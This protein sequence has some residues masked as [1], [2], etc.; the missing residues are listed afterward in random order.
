LQAQNLEEIDVTRDGKPLNVDL[1]Q[2]A[3]EGYSAVV[4]D[5]CD[6][7]G[8]R[9]QTMTPGIL[10]F[11]GPGTLAGRVR[12]ARSVAVSEVPGIHYAAEIAFLDSLG[13]GD[14]VLATAGD[15]PA[16][17]WGELFSAAA[18]ARGCRGAVI[19]G[20]VRDVLR[21]RALGFSV[22][23]RGARP[24]DSLGR[25][26]LVDTEGPLEVAGVKVSNGDIVVADA[27][28][29]VVVPF[30]AAE[31]VLP[32]ALDKAT[33]ERKGLTLLRDGALLADVWS[34]YGVL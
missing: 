17:I 16:A 9:D 1:D 24:T 23:A 22:Y 33:T 10:P 8:L 20:L 31:D 27:D 19:D 14:V 29:V 4:S 13:P 21:I 32:Q 5:A 15:A 26:S 30:N 28:G 3:A 12:V 25:V 34:R 11:S 7:V 6:Q 18:A 2:L